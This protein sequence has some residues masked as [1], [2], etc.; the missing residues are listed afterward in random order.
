LAVNR[1]ERGAFER[2]AV[3]DDQLDLLDL[4]GGR[5]G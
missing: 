2:R 3:V 4:A 5:V 1:G